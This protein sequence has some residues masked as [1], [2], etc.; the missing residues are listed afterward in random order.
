MPK[1]PGFEIIAAILALMV[2][3]MLRRRL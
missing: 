1:E 2:V 3:F